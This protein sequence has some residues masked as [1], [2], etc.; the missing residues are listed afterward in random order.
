MLRNPLYFTHL[1]D[2]IMFQDEVPFGYKN[3]DSFSL[4]G[5]ELEVEKA[6]ARQWNLVGSLSLQDY[7]GD[8]LPAAAPW[9]IKLGV[10]YELR[11]L[12]TIHLQLNSI[13]ERE[14]EDG[15]PRSDFE[16]TNQLDA[17]L[18]SRN[19]LDVGGLDFR[20]GLSNLLDEELKHPAPA[21]SY[22]GDYPYSEG[23]LL[24]VQLIYQP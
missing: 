11:P 17:S 10:D 3:G 15:D 12:T 6:I 9:M 14:R 8:A 20:I 1:D 22:A 18:R 16:Q 19:F 21:A 23:S 24:W 13:A 4:R 2:L 7:V 5:Y